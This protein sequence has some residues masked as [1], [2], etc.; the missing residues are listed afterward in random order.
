MLRKKESSGKILFHVFVLVVSCGYLLSAFSLGMPVVESQLKPSFFPMLIGFLS[1]IFS[2]ILFLREIRTDKASFIGEAR[3]ADQASDS[4][5]EKTSDRSAYLI[6]AATAVYI[7]A[8]SQIGY[9]LASA[10]YVFAVMVIFS[11]REKI[12]QKLAI[13]IVTVGIGYLVFEQMF[14]VR[15]PALWE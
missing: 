14:G 2:A 11:N 10:L 13:A 6:I 9:L 15:L 1:V 5:S 12:W 3:E 8:F 4:D 7:F